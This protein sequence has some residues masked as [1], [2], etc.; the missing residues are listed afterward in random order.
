MGIFDT[1]CH[2]ASHKYQDS[3]ELVTKIVE[4]AK[5]S[6]VTL[7]N[8]VGYDLETSI[9]ATQ[10]AQKYENV[11][12]TVGFHPTDVDRYQEDDY[13]KL[14]KLAASDKIIGIGEIGLDYFH[15]NVEPDVQKKWFKRQ[16]EIAQK[17]DLPV[18]IH[19]RD[20]YEDAYEIM[21]EMNVTKGL[22]HCY[23]GDLNMA[24]KFIDLGLYIS[25][26]GNIT[27]NNAQE[28]RDVAKELPFEKL[29]VETDAPYLTPHPYRGK[30]NYPNFIVYTVRKL[31]EIKQIPYEEMI[32]ITTRN[33]KNLFSIKDEF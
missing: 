22:M 6:N 25:F 12:A 29:L 13:V 19:C 30:L 26:A 11:Y 31:A 17:Y 16:I 3:E 24:K 23:N 10:Q 21:A 4:D 28:L 2:L 8:N 15:K 33:A 20:A 5:Q 32:R 7:I 27:F 1:H 9:L 18:I 14:D